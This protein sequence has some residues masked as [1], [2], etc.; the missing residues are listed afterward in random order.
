MTDIAFYHLQKSP[1]ETVLPVL[2]QKTLEAGKRAVVVAG[3]EDRVEAL[4]A[5]LWSAQ[6]DGWL[7][8]GSSKDGHAEDQPIWLTASHE[9]PNQA[10]FL[11][12][13]DGVA[14]EGFDGFERAF[15][16]FDGND[17]QSLQAARERWKSLKETDHALT[18]W[19]QDDNGRWIDKS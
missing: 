12:L 19:Q 7:P 15:D 14:A 17:D 2:L 13:A 1:L 16:L 5:A 11:F 18:Y 8:H 9:N 3:S 10:T 4:N 6:P